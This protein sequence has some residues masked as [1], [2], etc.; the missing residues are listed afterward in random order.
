MCFGRTKFRLAF[1]SF[2]CLFDQTRKETWKCTDHYKFGIIKNEG[3]IY[4]IVQIQMRINIYRCKY[5]FGMN[6]DI[7]KPKYLNPGIKHKN[8]G[9]IFSINKVGV[10][11]NTKNA[12]FIDNHLCDKWQDLLGHSNFTTKKSIT[13]WP[14]CCAFPSHFFFFN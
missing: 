10:R 5:I 1:F 11:D 8:I 13:I 4:R 2:V 12:K 14:A 6:A 3:K 9:C 7:P